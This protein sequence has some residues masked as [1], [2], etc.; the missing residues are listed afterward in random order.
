MDHLSPYLGM[1]RLWTSGGHHLLDVLQLTVAQLSST[2]P[3]FPPVM[4]LTGHWVEWTP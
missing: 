1:Y 2:E 3:I 4:A